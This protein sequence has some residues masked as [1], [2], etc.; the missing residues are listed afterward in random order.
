M[1]AS[2]DQQWRQLTA[3]YAQMWDD[4]LLNLA[5]DYKDLT[6]MAQQV[7]RDEMRK[8]NLGDPTAPAS[9]KP[10]RHSFL[11]QPG[12]RLDSPVSDEDL[13]IRRRRFADMLDRDLLRIAADYNILKPTARQAIRDEMRRRDLGDPVPLALRHDPTDPE[14]I[15]R[16]DAEIDA[17]LEARRALHGDEE[18]D[19]TWQTPLRDF[20]TRDEAI[21][22][23]EMLD[24]AGIQWWFRDPD[25]GR[26]DPTTQRLDY[27]ILV[28]ADQ[29]DDALEIIAQ[30]VPQDI[31]D[32][33]KIETPEYELPHCPRCCNQEPTLIATEPSNQWLC[34]SCGNEW[35]DPV[36]ESN[37]I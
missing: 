16:T 6:E 22:C 9:A 4:E 11:Q 26:G 8:R 24:R 7:L 21:Q 29:L 12:A 33:S 28:P 32:E 27:R 20:E 23:L 31:I 18:R 5:A 15:A 35:R 37:R 14:S 1:P 30:P 19:Y 34:E 25:R 10:A 17:R 13:Q 3:H 2:S 36:V